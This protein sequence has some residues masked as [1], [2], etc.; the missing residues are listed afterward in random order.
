[1]NNPAQL[2][3][4][5]ATFYQDVM[6][7]QGEK[8]HHELRDFLVTIMSLTCGVE[9]RQDFFTLVLLEMSRAFKT[10]DIRLLLGDPSRDSWTV[11]G[12]HPLLDSK[13]IQFLESGEPEPSDAGELKPIHLKST[14]HALLF[15]PFRH[16]NTPIMCLRLKWAK[17]QVPAWVGDEDS[18]ASFSEKLGSYL[19]WGNVLLQIAASKRHLQAIFDLIPTPV[20]VIGPDHILERVNK[21]FVD[22]FQRNFHD[23]IGRKCCEVVHRSPEPPSQCP[24]HKVLHERTRVE[25]DM[26]NGVRLHV[27]HLPM[28][29]SDGNLKALA[30][31]RPESVNEKRWDGT[32]SADLQFLRLYDSLSQPLTVISL[33]ADLMLLH[34]REGDS[35]D[36]VQITRREIDR[37]MSILKNEREG[38]M[39]RPRDSENS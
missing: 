3:S 5:G 6:I 25:M 27:T 7:H 35:T 30:L 37:I 28:Q 12:A 32:G 36:Y 34:P 19:A 11:V 10:S 21:A 20:G 24:L 13:S 22:F 38:F 18:L 17:D 2:H 23:T 14:E 8:M 39:N 29:N 26:E 16:L 9:R 4:P 33:I 15:L 31:F 1:M